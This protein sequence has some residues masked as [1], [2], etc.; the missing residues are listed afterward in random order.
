MAASD[1]RREDTMRKLQLKLEELAIESFEPGDSSPREGTVMGH[2][3]EVGG[4]CGGGET[5]VTCPV[6]NTCH[7]ALTCNG[8]VGCYTKD[9]GD[10]CA[11]TCGDSC[12]V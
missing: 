1:H 10:T 6:M 8:Q 2:A 7:V 9:F 12:G 3:T 11:F 5:C 4:P